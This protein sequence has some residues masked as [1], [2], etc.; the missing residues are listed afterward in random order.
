MLQN[1]SSAAVVT[2]DLRVKDGLIDCYIITLFI[3]L[4]KFP[5]VNH[6]T[7]SRN[8]VDMHSVKVA[9]TLLGQEQCH[10][11]KLSLEFFTRLET[12]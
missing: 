10:E 9:R 1:L 7:C 2:G 4:S 11:T 6:K 5:L 8:H 12:N 3:H